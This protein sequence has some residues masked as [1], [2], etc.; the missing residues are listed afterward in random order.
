[1][2]TSNS[3]RGESGSMLEQVLARRI[4]WLDVQP[5]QFRLQVSFHSCGCLSLYEEVAAR[6]VNVTVQDDGDRVARHCRRALL[7]TSQGA[8]YACR[9][10]G[11][12]DAKFAAD[13]L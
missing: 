12:L 9:D 2:D 7:R 13:A 3:R 4:Q 6:H 1:M 8:R 5:A 10:G 11:G